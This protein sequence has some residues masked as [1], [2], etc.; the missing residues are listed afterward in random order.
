MNQQRSENPV[1]SLLI[2]DDNPS[3]LDLLSTALEQPDLRI[4]TAGDP[5]VALDLIFDKHPDIV[6]TDLVMPK[7]SGLELLERIAAF[8]PAIDVILMTAHYS[9]ES[10]V[11]AIRKGASDYLNK[12]VSIPALRERIGTMIED[13][14]RRHRTIQLQDELRGNS[15]FEKI[16]GNSSAMW[17]LFST[18]RRIAPHFRTVLITGPT[19]SGKD[20]VTQALHRLSPSSSGNLVVVNCS[21]VVETLFESELFGHVKGAFTGATHDKVGLV[22]HASGGTLFLDEIGDMPLGT[23]AKLLRTIQNQEVQRVGSLQAR[24]V[25]FRVIAVTHRDLQAMIRDA[26]FREDLFY[27][28]SMVEIRI[29]PLAERREDVPLLARHFIEKF[30]KQFNKPVRGMTQRAS[31]ALSRYDWPGNV[32][33]LENAIGHACMMVLSDTIDVAD[34]PEYL[35]GDTSRP[36]QPMTIPSPAEISSGDSL[37][38]NSERRLIA[39]ALAKTSGN[40]SEA[41]RLLRIGRDALRYKMKKYGLAD[42]LHS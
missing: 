21:A 13:A 40:Q 10:A 42:P 1:V 17:E 16:I 39:D 4:F 11:E 29:P 34:L 31:I 7:M 19:G 24:K 30:S 20:L 37:L 36:Q 9:T 38:E 33:E 15:E 27:R 2:V 3:S 6:L 32:R 26:R 18:I 25:N 28:L 5:E 23:Q 8:D 22:E 41:A 14:R 12:P 35:R